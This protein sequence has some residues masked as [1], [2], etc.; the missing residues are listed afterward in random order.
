MA[1]QGDAIRI[2]N[3]VRL[4]RDIPA[5]N[6][7][8]FAFVGDTHVPLTAVPGEMASAVANDDAQ[9]LLIAGDVIDAGSNCPPST[10]ETQLTTW[11][12]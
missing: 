11:R 2:G 10:F 4:E 6:S 5:T 1:P 7:W 12:E 8:R 3:Y 9:L